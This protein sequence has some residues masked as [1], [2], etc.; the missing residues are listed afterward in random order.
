VVQGRWGAESPP[1]EVSAYGTDVKLLYRLAYRLLLGWWWVRRPVT[2]GVKGIVR[3]AEGRFLL[4]RPSY[5]P[6]WHLPGG[7]VGRGEALDEAVRRELREEV[8]VDAGAVRLFGVYTNF[9][10][11]KSDHIVCF[12]VEEW[13]PTGAPHRA[14]EIESFRF[15]APD[16]L[17]AETTPATRAR[18]AEVVAGRAPGFRWQVPS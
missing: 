7:G 15:F 1:P 18:I 4:I 13:R 8:S 5:L 17:P 3:D 10:E 2:L 6:G 16:D 9:R 14:H 12:V 11:W